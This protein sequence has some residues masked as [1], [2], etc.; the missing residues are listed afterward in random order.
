MI[1]ECLF[2]LLNAMSLR[3]DFDIFRRAVSERRKLYV[4]Q[5]HALTPLSKG[6]LILGKTN[7]ITVSPSPFSPLSSRLV[8]ISLIDCGGI[9]AQNAIFPSALHT[10]RD[11]EMRLMYTYIRA[12]LQLR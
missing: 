3:I 8:V 12:Q 9:R 6:E 4:V 5:L 1:A 10:L 7:Q 2:N 11:N